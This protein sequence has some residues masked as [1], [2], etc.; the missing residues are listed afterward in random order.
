MRPAAKPV[1]YF[2]L[3]LRH[4]LHIGTRPDGM[5]GRLGRRWTRKEFAFRVGVSES[6]VAKWLSDKAHP[7]DF[8]SVEAALFGDNLAYE[9]A[10]RE[11]R[12][13]YDL[14]PDR[15]RRPAGLKAANRAAIKRPWAINAIPIIFL[16]TERRFMIAEG[17]TDK[18]VLL[19]VLS[20]YQRP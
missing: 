3:L 19:S 7:N 9:S 13:A 1:S 2:C 8:A 4:H 5:P 10:R 18:Q 15:R 6:T 11:F 14:I 12:D 16:R 20:L 17:I